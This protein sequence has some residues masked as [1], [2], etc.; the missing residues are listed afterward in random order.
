MS[1]LNYQ[2][3]PLIKVC[4][5]LGLSYQKH[6]YGGN[7]KVNNFGGLVI[8]DSFFYQ[9]STG[10]KGGV[11]KFIMLTQG[12]SYQA[13]TDLL[14]SLFHEDLTVLESS[15]QKFPGNNQEH[16][17]KAFIESNW[18]TD[19]RVTQ[20]LLS[21]GIEK[22]IIHQ[23]IASNRIKGVLVKDHLNVAF[24]C[25]DLSETAD[26]V[27]GAII[28]GITSTF[29]GLLKDSDGSF[30]YVIPSS[31]QQTRTV[32]LFEAPID[33]LSFLTL[34]PQDLS[35]TYVAMGGVKMSVVSKI[36]DFYKPSILICCTDNDKAGHDFYHQLLEVY[37]TMRIRRLIPKLKDWNE[38]LTT[39][40]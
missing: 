37:P 28:R 13:A 26:S 8:K 36:V 24:L 16:S 32:Y 33:L 9:H 7:Y 23:E 2:S 19:D 11:V 12:C 35:S 39:T 3:I 5:T 29:K 21:R 6:G 18:C 27:K 22:N 14:K 31:T 38:D 25:R 15:L 34:H 30:G 1:F 10:E 40:K 17:K 20:Y 4:Q